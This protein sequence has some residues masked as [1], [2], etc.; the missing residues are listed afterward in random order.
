MSGTHALVL[1]DEVFAID[2]LDAATCRTACARPRRTLERAEEDSE[3]RAPG[4]AREAPLR[5]V[6]ASSPAE[7]DDPPVRAAAAEVAAAAAATLLRV[8]ERALAERLITYDT[9]SRT[10]S[11][12]AA[13]F[14]KGWLEAREIDV[15]DH[16]F[17]EPAGAARRRRAASRARR[18]SSTAT[19]TSSPAARSSSRRASRATACIGRG[20]Y[21]MKGG[22]GGDDVRAPRRRRAGRGARALRLRA[23]RGVRGHRARARPTSSSAA[24]SRGDFAITGEPTDLHVGVQAKGVLAVPAQRPR[25][26]GA[27]LDAV[28]GRQRGPEG[29]RRLPANRVPALLARVLRAVR[30]A[31]DQPRADPGRRRAQQGPRPLLHGRRHPLPAQPG[32]RRHPRADPDDPG[33][34]GRARPS[35]ACPRTSRA[36]TPTCSR[37]RDAVGRLTAGRVD[38]RRPRRRLRR[39]LVPRRGHPGGRVRPRRRGPPR[40]GGV[41]LDLLAGALPPGAAATSCAA[42]RPRSAR[43]R[44]RLRAVEGGLA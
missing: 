10:A 1:V 7:A 20:A 35:S 15:D 13:G 41:G 9:S 18:S 33:H 27:R 3:E 43:A 8:D 23:R 11:A 14:V 16:D 28:A 24:A 37:C 17:G 12:P 39:D 6:L 5:G 25:P 26:R 40:P 29:D 22:A 32:P 30:P 44:A 2:E 31:V 21:D 38:E 19:S 42:C 34:R 36:P 4:R